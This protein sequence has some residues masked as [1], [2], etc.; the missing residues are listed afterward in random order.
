MG[1]LET[2]IRERAENDRHPEPLTDLNFR[3]P[4]Q[5]AAHAQI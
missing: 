5:S 4:A 3:V 2:D 1:H